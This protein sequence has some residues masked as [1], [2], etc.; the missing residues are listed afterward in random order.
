MKQHYIIVGGSKG[1]GQS[2]AQLLLEQGHIVH[3]IARTAPEWEGAYHFYACD[4]LNDELPAIEEAISGLIYCPGSINLKPF[5]SL[6]EKDF[7]KDFDINVLGAIKVLQGYYKSLKAAENPAVVLFSTV[8][9]QTGMGFHASVAVAKGAIEGLTRSLAAEWAPT[10]RV[11]AIAPS[12]TQTDLAA[13]L[14]RNEKQ[15]EAADGRHPLNRIGQPQDVAELAT[16]LVTDKSSWMT[17]Q[18]VALDGGMGA[19]KKI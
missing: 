19:I 16:F 13:R 9:V 18:V 6:K 17:G 2:T 5:K 11:N 4:V 10:I 12:I 3:I 7:Q 15:V 8:A 14:L 1:I